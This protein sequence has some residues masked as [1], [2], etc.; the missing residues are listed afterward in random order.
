[1]GLSENSIV[2]R[3]LGTRELLSGHLLIKYGMTCNGITTG[4]R[5]VKSARASQKPVFSTPETFIKNTPASGRTLRRVRNL[6]AMFPF[7][8]CRRRFHFQAVRII[9]SIS[10]KHGFHP[11]PV[12]ACKAS[13]IWPSGAPSRCAALLPWKSCGPSL[14]A[15]SQQFPARKSPCHSPNSMPY[16]KR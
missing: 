8:F 14:A 13:S 7:E 1:M 4:K 5:G 12:A 16:F 2:P 10:A 9:S 15:R 11:S 6:P 3:G